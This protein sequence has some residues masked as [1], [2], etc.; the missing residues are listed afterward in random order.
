MK[1]NYRKKA[2]KVGEFIAKL[3]AAI[4]SYVPVGYEDETGFHYGVNAGGGF[5]LFFDSVGQP[6][7]S[8]GLFT[9]TSL[10]CIARIGFGASKTISRGDAD[11]N[12]L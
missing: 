2:L 12:A 4:A 8:A 5:L 3:R 9:P 10:T 11:N 7:F 6:L 1:T